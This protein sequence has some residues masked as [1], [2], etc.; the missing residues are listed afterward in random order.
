M[1]RGASPFPCWWHCCLGMGGA[2]PDLVEPAFRALHSDTIDLL[3]Y[4]LYFGL[5]GLLPC[6]PALGAVRTAAVHADSAH[7]G[8]LRI[9]G[10]RIRS[11]YSPSTIR[12]VPS[13]PSVRMEC[14]LAEPFSRCLIQLL[15]VYL[16]IIIS[17]SFSLQQ[18]YQAIW[19][20]L[21]FHSFGGG[22]LSCR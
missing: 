2:D 19:H 17:S 20:C 13:T 22:M 16:E 4:M 7:T 18:T 6:Y 5:Q 11:L 8:Q 14:N 3:F 21:P 9:Q 15:A 1:F 10:L 12:S